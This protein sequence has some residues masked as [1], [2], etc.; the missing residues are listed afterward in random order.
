[1]ANNGKKSKCFTLTE[2]GTTY[3]G[4]I[5]SGKIRVTTARTAPGQNMTV[6][7]F[8]IASKTWHNDSLPKNVKKKFEAAF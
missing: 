8:D 1:M 7:V 6:G 4:T 5:K 3:T 2:N